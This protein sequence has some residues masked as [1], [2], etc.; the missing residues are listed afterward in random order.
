M[1]QRSKTKCPPPRL[2]SRNVLKAPTFRFLIEAFFSKVAKYTLRLLFPTTRTPCLPS[3]FSHTDFQQSILRHCNTGS[4]VYVILRDVSH[5]KYIWIHLVMYI[6]GGHSSVMDKKV[7]RT[8]R[9]FV[10]KS[11]QD[12]FC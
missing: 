9:K 4:G 12:I 10:I 2:S 3:P 8:K 7:I 1:K 5:N 11:H 6:L